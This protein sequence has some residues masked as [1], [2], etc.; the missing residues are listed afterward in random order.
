MNSKIKPNKTIDCRGLFCPMPVVKTRLELENMLEGEILEVIADDPGFEKDFPSWCTA[1]G[2]EF[3]CLIKE[4]N[5]F[6]GYVRKR[7]K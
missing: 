7:K 1:A 4:N 6:L 5:L 2:E 3:L